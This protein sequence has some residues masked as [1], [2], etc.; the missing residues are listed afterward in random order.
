MGKQNSRSTFA[1][2][3]MLVTILYLI[4][5]PSCNRIPPEYRE[6][7]NLPID[8]QRAQLR[9]YPIDK[10]I[11]YYLAATTYVRP[12]ERELGDVVA[13]NGKEAVPFLVKRIKEETQ[14]H[15]QMSLMYVFGEMNRRYYD[16]KDE[17]EALETLKYVTA[18]M[19]VQKAS[20][21]RVLADI[22]ENR[23]SDLRKLKEAHPEYFPPSQ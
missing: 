14:E 1:F 10:Q 17:K 18:N 11:D 22:L 19:S 5:L 4:V 9:T 16:L 21:E 6:F 2:L 20:A 23:P 8:H 7:L 15:R 3:G 13:S 12:P